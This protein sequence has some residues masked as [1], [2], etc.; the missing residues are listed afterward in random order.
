MKTLA[1]MRHAQAEKSHNDRER[2]LTNKG[3]DEA[4]QIVEKLVEAGI[5]PDII[6]VSDARRARETALIAGDIMGALDRIKTA[7]ALY[8]GGLRDYVKA[9]DAI[10]FKNETALV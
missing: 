7:D 2:G 3:R 4:A 6:L 5:K 8:E 9:I 1:L 10:A